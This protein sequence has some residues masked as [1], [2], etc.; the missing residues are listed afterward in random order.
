VMIVFDP[1]KHLT[2]EAGGSKVGNYDYSHWAQNSIYE[3][4]RVGQVGS[5]SGA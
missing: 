2:V 5:P 4:W 3:F 1:A